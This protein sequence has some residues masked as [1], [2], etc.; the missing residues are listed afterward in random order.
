MTYKEAYKYFKKLLGCSAKS[1]EDCI[2]KEGC[3]HCE[4]DY[5]SEDYEKAL[6]T[7]IRALEKQIPKKVVPFENNPYLDA[8]QCC[9]R[10][11]SIYG[12]HYCS[13]CGQRIDWSEVG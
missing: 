7:A 13:Y 3:E 8:C 12:D 6:V 1:H 11:K 4:Y 2:G 9:G 5:D 10:I